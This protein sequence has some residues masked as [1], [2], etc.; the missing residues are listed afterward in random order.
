MIDPLMNQLVIPSEDY[1]RQIANI[2]LTSDYGPPIYCDTA[3]DIAAG[4]ADE[5]Y[6]IACNIVNCG[7]Q[8]LVAIGRSCMTCLTIRTNIIFDST[9]GIILTGTRKTL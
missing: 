2:D 9:G 8:S 5:Y 4:A 7:L 6:V 1:P 3:K